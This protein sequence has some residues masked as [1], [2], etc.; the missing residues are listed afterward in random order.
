MPRVEL[1]ISARRLGLGSSEDLEKQLS[2]Y[3]DRV[4]EI[5]LGLFEHRKEASDFEARQLFRILNK[6]IPGA[7]GRSRISKA[8]LFPT[9][10][11]RWRRSDR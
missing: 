2:A 11:R 8:W 9:G 10:R 6:E 3:R 1:E 4:H 5:Y 7:G